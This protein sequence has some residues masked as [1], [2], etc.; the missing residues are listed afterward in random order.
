MTKGEPF[1]CKFKSHIEYHEGEFER[2]STVLRGEKRT[3]L[4]TFQNAVNRVTLAY[5]ELA[6][7]TDLCVVKTEVLYTSNETVEEPRWSATFQIG[8]SM[9]N[10]QLRKAK[11]AR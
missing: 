9:S 7:G 11:L 1:R 10:Y 6:N 4:E 2:I 3:D 8:E 5:N